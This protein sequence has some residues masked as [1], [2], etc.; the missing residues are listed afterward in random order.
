[1]SVCLGESGGGGG[2]GELEMILGSQV[3]K[4]KQQESPS[5]FTVQYTVLLLSQVSEKRD[6]RNVCQCAQSVILEVQVVP[7]ISQ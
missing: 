4:N 6:S 1:M 2:G 5:I 7:V 3:S